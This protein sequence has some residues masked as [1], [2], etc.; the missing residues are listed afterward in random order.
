MSEGALRAILLVAGI[1]QLATGLLA[2]IAPGTF[3]EEIGRYGIENLHYVGD[4]GAFQVAAGVGL[5]V[6]AE[7][8]SWRVPILTVGAVWL[9]AHAINHAFDVDEARS[10]ARGVFDTVALALGAVGSYY[11]ARVADRLRRGAPAETSR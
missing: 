10:D 5:L 9:A 11:L 1:L 2:M 7:R 3:F 6:A 8:S 4:V